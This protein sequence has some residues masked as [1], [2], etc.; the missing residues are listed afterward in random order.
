M[1]WKGG[2]KHPEKGLGDDSNQ[3]WRRGKKGLYIWIGP[4][5]FRASSRTSSHSALPRQA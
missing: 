3:V 4:V 2:H 5:F 1:D